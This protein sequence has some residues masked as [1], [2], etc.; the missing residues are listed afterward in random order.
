[1]RGRTPTNY[2]F[3]DFDIFN[4]QLQ[5]R[6]QLSQTIDNSDAELILNGDVDELSKRFS[7][8]FSLAAPE[9]IEGAVSLTVEE[10]SVDVS[11]DYRYGF[12]RGG[13]H[14]APGITASYFVPFSGD[15]RMFKC[16]P[17]TFISGVPVAEVG[18]GEL[19]LTF[20]RAGQDVGATKME[21]DLALDR[22][23][24]NLGWLKENCQT[25]NMN[26]PA[27]ARRA[28]SARRTRLQQMQQG[29]ESL[30]IPIRRSS[31]APQAVLSKATAAPLTTG[32]TARASER[33]AVKYDVALSFAGE[34]R[35]YVDEVAKGLRAAGVSVFYDEF[36][37]IELWG[38]NLIEHL[39]KIY[40]QQS[41]YVV[42]FISK[43]YVE[44]AWTTHE[45]QHAQERALLAR[46]EYILPARFDDTPVPGMTSTVAFQDLRHINPSELVSLIVGKLHQ[47]TH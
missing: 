43:E 19:R 15:A 45:R 30:G 28:V 47:K 42:M 39:A 29:V 16:R 33:P 27:E 7:E 34:N 3:A 38:R 41:R 5:Q 40:G 32:E 17:S 24:Q 44:K 4:L 46:E 11:G 10:E 25:F 31:L 14:F 13:S 37:R 26:L 20:T 1:M 18:D 9:L 2:L 12:L 23:R 21:F 22:I 8:Q 36:E 35:G 6:Q